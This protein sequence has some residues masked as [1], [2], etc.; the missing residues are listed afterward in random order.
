MKPQLIDTWSEF[1]ISDG[2][3][4]A[5]AG[6]LRYKINVAYPKAIEIR[7]AYRHNRAN[8]DRDIAEINRL[9]Q[10][11]R[12]VLMAHDRADYVNCDTSA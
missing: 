12:T 10:S 3:L 8:K 1:G 5:T 7:E 4:V 9:M 2:H 11:A 6:E